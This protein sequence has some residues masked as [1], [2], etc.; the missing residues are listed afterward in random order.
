MIAIPEPRPEIYLPGQAPA[1]TLIASC[2]ERFFCSFHKVR[3]LF[4]VYLFTGM[5]SPQMG[6]MS[7]FVVGVILILKPFLELSELSDLIWSYP[8]KHLL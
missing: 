5:H 8:G 3:S 4:P 6:N 7:V 1:G 2:N